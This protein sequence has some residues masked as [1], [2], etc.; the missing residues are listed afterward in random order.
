ML[1][2]YTTLTKIFMKIFATHVSGNFQLSNTLIQGY[3]LFKSFEMYC[4]D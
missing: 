3:V 1:Y 4:G 2:I